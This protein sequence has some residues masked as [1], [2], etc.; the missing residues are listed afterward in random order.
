MANQVIFIVGPPRTG[1]TFVDNALVVNQPKV[2]GSTIE[3]MIYAISDKNE[4]SAD[5]VFRNQYFRSLLNDDEIRELTGRSRNYI[6]L[7]QNTISHVCK[8][9]SKD[10]FVEKSPVHSKYLEH[11]IRDF[12]AARFIVLERNPAATIHSMV[13]ASWI[14]LLSDKLGPLKNSKWL[15]YYSAMLSYVRYKK[16]LKILDDKKGVKRLRFEDIMTGTIDLR[17]ELSAFL[18]VELDKLYQVK[19]FSIDSK[20]KYERD[21]SRVDSYRSSMP[22]FWQKIALSVEDKRKASIQTLLIRKILI[23]LI[24]GRP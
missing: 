15:K 20:E 18:E 2:A 7:F 6:E 5:K 1:T 11:I 14:P 8:R 13:Q 3:S 22:A 10:V 17:H 16:A 24:V 23:D 19:S 4:Y 9:D 12:P 21:S